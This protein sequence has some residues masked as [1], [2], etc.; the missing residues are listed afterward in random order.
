MR[1]EQQLGAGGGSSRCARHAPGHIFPC[2][3]NKTP[4]IAGYERHRRAAAQREKWAPFREKKAADAHCFSVVRRSD[5]GRFARL[6]VD[7]AASPAVRGIDPIGPRSAP[8]LGR[9]SNGQVGRHQSA[10][11][12][13]FVSARCAHS[14]IST[15]PVA[16]NHPFK[17]QGERE[18]D[19]DGVKSYISLLEWRLASEKR[20][21]VL[22]PPY[23]SARRKDGRVA[24]R[25]GRVSPRAGED[26]NRTWRD[27]CP[28]L[29]NASVRDTVSVALPATG[30]VPGLSAFRARERRPSSCSSVFLSKCSNSEN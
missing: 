15:R 26:S 14:A 22:F 20:H 25:N 21:L 1:G 11:S 3:A 30:S 12:I 29:E 17:C 4:G 2:S 5:D 7:R 6:D 28:R 18:R 10:P 27:C 13:V 16:K 19:G 23:R 8:H 24:A 9:L